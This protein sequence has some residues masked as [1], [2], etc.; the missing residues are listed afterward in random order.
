MPKEI[1]AG[2]IAYYYDDSKSEY[3]FLMA[4]PGGPYFKNVNKYGFPKGHV[5]NDESYEHAAIREFQEE[6]G[7]HIK[8]YRNCRVYDVFVEESNRTVHHIMVFYDVD[9]NLEQQD[10]ISEKLED[11]L[12]DS[13]GI[14]WIDLEKLDIKNSSPPILKLQQELSND[15]TTLDKEVYKNWT[16]L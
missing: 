13:S 6:T 10:T 16:I 2:V 9:I 4:H 7:Y 11:E 3:K 8:G 12:N 15:K 5:E 14:Y 1:A